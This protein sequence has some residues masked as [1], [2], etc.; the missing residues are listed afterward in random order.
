MVRFNWLAAV[1][2]IG[3]LALGLVMTKPAHADV[4][5]ATYSTFV[6]PRARR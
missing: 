4:G 3:A 5:T 2:V 1:A 6:S